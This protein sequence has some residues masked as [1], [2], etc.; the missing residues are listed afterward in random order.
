MSVLKFGELPTC[1]LQMFARDKQVF[2]FDHSACSFYLFFRHLSLASNPS[3][4]RVGGTSI[5][6]LGCDD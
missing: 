5:N 1:R 4:A 2:C 6:Q 3:D